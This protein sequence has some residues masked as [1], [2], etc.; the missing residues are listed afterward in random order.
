MWT[1]NTPWFDVAVFMSLFATGSI[2]FGHLEQH[3]PAWRRLLKVAI[4]VAILISLLETVGRLWAYGVLALLFAAAGTYHFWWLSKHGINGW[5]GEPRD[6]F[7]E[8]V[9][10]NAYRSMEER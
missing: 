5:T 7:L 9:G 3:K 4:F 10:R 1:I 2:L 8:L 6:K